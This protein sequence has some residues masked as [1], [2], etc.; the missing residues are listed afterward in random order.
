[1]KLWLLLAASPVWA[2]HMLP[3]S[4]KKST[5]IALAPA[6]NTR[7]ELARELV[8][9]AEARKAQARGALLPNLDGSVS[10]Q[11]V[12]RNLKAF[13]LSFTGLPGIPGVPSFSFP[14]FVGPFSIF[15]ARATATQNVLDLS[16]IRRYKAST[17]GVEAARNEQENTRHQVT[18]QVARAYLAA[19]RAD[20]RVDAAR[21]NAELA[22][23]LLRLA[24]S[25]RR[26]GTGLAIEVTRAEAQLA[27]ERQRLE[28]AGNERNKAH[29]QLLRVM[30]LRLDTKLDLTDRLAYQPAEPVSYEQALRTALDGRPDWKAQ[31]SRE[32]VA[33]ISYSATR[34]ERL[35]SITA[36]GDYGPIGPSPGDSRSTR[37]AGLALRVPIFDGG[38]R[39]ARRAESASQLRVEQIRTRDLREQLELELRIAFDNLSSAEAQVRTAEEGLRLAEKELEQAQRRYKAGVATS[40]EITDAQTRLARAR[41][42]RISALFQ[43]SLARLDLGTA[44]GAV[45]RF[46]P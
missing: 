19:V 46:L 28:A 32:R 5:E 13:G 6:G 43:H 12:T 41:E 21:A 36:F 3:L 15:D 30:D 22:E 31:Q 27:N 40:I 8:A 45:G 20:A 16:S 23:A 37:A 1:M 7:I 42:N 24:E 38:R 17:A 2:Q 11:D 10:Y 9:Q 39:D 4:M 18:D 14:A 26:A 29:L 35:P 25:Q 44:M 34:S 33:Q